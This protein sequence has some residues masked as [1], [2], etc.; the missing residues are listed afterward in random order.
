M[1]KMK[2]KVKKQTFEKAIVELITPLG[3]VKTSPHH[4]EKSLPDNFA[5]IV[6]VDHLGRNFWYVVKGDDIDIILPTAR[7]GRGIASFR[8]WL[9]KNKLIRR[10]A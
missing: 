3:F 10:A 9:A 8:E 7:N 2:S 1:P 6:E 5:W 4:Y